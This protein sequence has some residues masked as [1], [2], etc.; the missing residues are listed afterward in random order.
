M[1][2]LDDASKAPSD[3]NYF[4]LALSIR[5]RVRQRGTSAGEKLAITLSIRADL[6]GVRSRGVD[7]R[8]R[9]TKD[10]YLNHCAVGG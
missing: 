4:R 6:I 5:R 9:G 7:E 2:S 10:V 1:F 8:I 3:F